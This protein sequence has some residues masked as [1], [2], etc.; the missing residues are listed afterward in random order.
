MNL[1]EFGWKGYD[2]ETINVPP[3]AQDG[4]SSQQS[5]ELDDDEGKTWG[6]WPEDADELEQ[7]EFED[8]LQ[9]FYPMPYQ[10]PLDNPLFDPEDDP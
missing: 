6:K 1:L 5:Q 4:W 7:Q 9:E 2:T 8:S 10:D 3:S